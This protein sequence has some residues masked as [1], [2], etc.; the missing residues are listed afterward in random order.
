MSFSFW[1]EVKN[2]IKTIDPFLRKSQG[3]YNAYVTLYL[4]RFGMIHG[5]L[6]PIH[7]SLSRTHNLEKRRSLMKDRCG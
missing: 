3:A 7:G 4:I 1:G 2:L 6:N 5:P